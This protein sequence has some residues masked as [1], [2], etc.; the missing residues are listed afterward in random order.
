[1]TIF[2]EKYNY[3]NPL[4]SF[5][6]KKIFAIGVILLLLPSQVFAT[7][8]FASLYPHPPTAAEEYI[9]IENTGC[10]TLNLRDYQLVIG[11]V[12][13]KNLPDTPLAPNGVFR[14]AKPDFSFRLNDD[15]DTLK[16]IA[17]TSGETQ[18][19]VSYTSAD[20][21]LGNVVHFSLANADCT[22]PPPPPPSP[23]D[24]GATTPP[25][26]NTSTETD[27][28]TPIPTDSGAVISP[29]DSEATMPP[30]DSGA[31]TN[32]PT[33]SG[34]TIPPVIDEEFVL[35][36]EL[37]YSDE[38]AD[39]FIDTLHIAYTEN[40][41]GSV[42]ISKIFLSSVTGGLSDYEIKNSTGMILSGSLSGN[43][44]TLSLTG[45]TIAKNTL[46]IASDTTSELV[47]TS[48]ENLGIFGISGLPV[49]K[50]SEK[51][52]ENYTNIIHPSTPIDFSDTPST[53]TGAI[54]SE[55]I[56]SSGSSGSVS[57]IE[58]FPKV[59]PTIQNYTTATLSGGNM[60]QCTTNPCRINLNFEPIFTENFPMKN[61]TCEITFRGEK[62]QTCNP[63]QWT[64][65]GAENFS[66]KIT[67]KSDSSELQTAY[68]VHLPSPVPVQNEEII[69]PKILENPAPKPAPK[70]QKPQEFSS[71]PIIHIIS[72]GKYEKEY[73]WTDDDE[74][75]C[76]SS[77]CAVNLSAS[78][79][80]SLENKTLKY[81]WKFG[82]FGEQAGK[83]P[84]TVTFSPGNHHIVLTVT[85]SL[86]SYSMKEIIVHVPDISEIEDVEAT[87]TGATLEAKNTRKKAAKEVEHIE[88][89]APELI[90]QNPAKIAQDGENYICYTETN[91]CSFNF[92]LS[93]A[94]S[95]Y[96]YM[97]HWDD[98]E[99]FASKNPKSKSLS[100]GN[101]TLKI[102]TYKED[103]PDTIIWK[104]SIEVAVIKTTKSKTTKVVKAKKTTPKKT[105]TKKAI[106]KNTTE[107]TLDQEDVPIDEEAPENTDTIQFSVAGMMLSGLLFSR[108]RKKGI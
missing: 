108:L 83:N 77:T 79:T 107:N 60:L 64:L 98:E 100:I 2:A 10:D 78:G 97:W 22:P 1:M 14:I 47:L 96:N 19:S 30:A 74:I 21:K 81:H 56:T 49:E 35:T 20:A 8:K 42:D 43:I 46:H 13:P 65:S 33:N 48:V 93:G 41:T 73:E 101:H 45:V 66:L 50:F 6:M 71:P 89:S 85:D 63:P 12:T 106:S 55:A 25:T 76:F 104:K 23:V 90:L 11:T 28:I 95:E 68:F 15:G 52:F 18:D 34:T 70:S 40:L 91:S 59:T 24:S 103:D 54:N 102:S 57:L 84:K 31:T 53:D 5:R 99:G 72:Q 62:L 9:E 51:S 29:T 87:L 7:L 75:S 86:G 16:L 4:I 82:E 69:I 92:S 3:K 32:S 105:S 36:D 94:I 88:F 39:G 37:S 44:L 38:N 67:K 58:I 26:E 80:Y 17:K 61:Y 27:T